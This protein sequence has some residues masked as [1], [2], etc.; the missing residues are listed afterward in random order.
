MTR[1]MRSLLLIGF[2]AVV[3]VACGDNNKGTPDAHPHP[4]PDAAPVVDAPPQVDGIADARAAA[5][6]MGL[7]LP[8]HHVTV[9]YLKPQIG[10]T[11][12]DPAGFTIQAA[13][14]GPA[15]FISVDPA[16]LTPA[17]VAGDVVDFTITQMGTVGMQRRAQAITDF[18][19]VSQGASIGALAQDVS[20]ATDLVSALDS[21]DSE[22]VTVTG[23]L[24]GAPASS[25][26]GFQRF[27]LT[28]AGITGDTNLQLRV[29]TTVVN[30]IDMAQNCNITATNI[31]FGR[32][33]AAAELGVFGV[34]ELAMSGC[35][36][37]TVATA[38]ALSATTVRVTFTRNIEPGSVMADGS[39]FTFDNGLVAS[40]V[41]VSGRTA[42]VTTGA[43][44]GGTTYNV[45]VAATVTDLQGTAVGAPAN[46]AFG[47][48]IQQ[49]TV[50]INELNANIT[51]GCDLI[52]LRVTGDGSMAGYKV[53]ERT[54]VIASSELSF[55]FP[56]GFS[57]HKNDLV[58]LHMG[59]GSATCNP[60]GAT[61]EL[62]TTAD[63]PNA[64]FGKNYDTAFDFYST[65]AGLLATDNVITLFD[66][67]PTILDAVFV[68]NDPAGASTA[69]NTL[70][71][72][73]AA[74]AASQ[75]SPAQA[76]YTS[77][78]FRTAAVDDL[79]ATGTAATGTSIQR[80]DDTDDNDKADWTSGAGVTSTFGALNAG[81]SAL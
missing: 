12:N 8:I 52:E 42:L 14:P 20:A 18:T 19:R 76:T 61:Q 49:A 66:A 39:Q 17:P 41:T 58:V 21:Y 34:S 50:R 47:G 71:A 37:P 3:G 45:T 2:L 11:V 56:T 74:G 30:A 78:E 15:L 7:S 4:H 67:T 72:A 16:T 75:W 1:A 73:A 80:I 5:D 81:Q 69:A 65:D 68:S 55:T 43:Q 22:L 48:Y 31:P 13:K 51:T 63:Q 57:V 64:T 28:T 26:S 24:A 79:D 32:F 59:S 6:G 9:T 27:T 60:G 53:T 36:A 23:T 33:N 40:A 54:G 77:T 35:A 44:A 46:T 62:T 70:T 29:P 10:S 25:G 38:I